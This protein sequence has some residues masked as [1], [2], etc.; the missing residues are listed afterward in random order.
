MLL[1]SGIAPVDLVDRR[2]HGDFGRAAQ[3]DDARVG[4]DG[5][6]P[7]GKAH[8]NPVAAEQRQLA[9]RAAP[10]V[11]CATPLDEHLQEGRDRVPD[12]DAVTPHQVGPARRLALVR[13]VRQHDG[14][15]GR[16]RAEHVVGGHVEAE[17]RERQQASPGPTPKRRL[18]SVKL[19]TRPRWSTITA[20]GFPVEPE[21]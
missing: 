10:L 14:R 4:R 13:G 18:K 21:V 6:Q 9:D 5:S 17:R 1:H 19:L 8:R 2:I 16:Q 11:A 15:P 20:F 3:R 7:P 12:R